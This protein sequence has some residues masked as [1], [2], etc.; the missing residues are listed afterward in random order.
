MALSAS[1]TAHPQLFVCSLLNADPLTQDLSQ[2]LHAEHLHIVSADSTSNFLELLEQQ[3]HQIDCLLLPGGPQLSQI[4]DFLH[5][6]AIVLPAVVIEWE[7]ATSADAPTK[8]LPSQPDY[9]QA[10][11]RV[12]PSQLASWGLQT[13]SSRLNAEAEPVLGRLVERAINQFLKLNPACRLDTVLK[14]LVP[15]TVDQAVQTFVT[16]QQQRLT[17]KLRERLGYLSLYYRRDPNTFFRHLPAAEKQKFL[18]E[19]KADYRQIILK[20]FRRDQSLNDKID[21]YVTKAFL[22]DVSVSQVLEIHMELIDAFAKQLKLEGRNEDILLDYR[23][24]LIDTIAHLC[25]MYRRS[26][27]RD[28]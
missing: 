1:E 7:P 2:F 20:Y 15:P 19:L 10:E 9:H 14:P 25:E 13:S 16:M 12:R 11:L 6:K 17:E 18:E 28:S 22:A 4:T 24:T 8:P 5:K 27:P 23:L 3:K 26:V 21:D